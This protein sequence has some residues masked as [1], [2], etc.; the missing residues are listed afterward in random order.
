MTEVPCC[1]LDQTGRL[2]VIAIDIL[3]GDGKINEVL[4]E[5]TK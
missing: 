1:L 3:D 5:V 2:W 4:S